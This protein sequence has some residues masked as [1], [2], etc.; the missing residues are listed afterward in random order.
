M[1]PPLLSAAE[2]DARPWKRK[3]EEVG[4][5]HSPYYKIRAAV[6]DLRGRFL[7][8][9]TPDPIFSVHSGWV[10]TAASCVILLR[11]KLA[12]MRKIILHSDQGMFIEQ[13]LMVEYWQ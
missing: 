5:H 2:A 13:Y 3:L 8:V 1:K 6:A 11:V 9:P 7:Q 12:G 10:D 4:F